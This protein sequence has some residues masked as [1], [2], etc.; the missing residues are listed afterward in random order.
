MKTFDEM[1][2]ELIDCLSK[3]DELL[4]LS[5]KNGKG[6]Y[7]NYYKSIDYIKKIKEDYKYDIVSTHFVAYRSFISPTKFDRYSKKEYRFY[8]R[9]LIRKI[10]TT[11][12]KY[13]VKINFLALAGLFEIIRLYEPSKIFDVLLFFYHNEKFDYDIYGEFLKYYDEKKYIK[14]KRKEVLKYL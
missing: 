10:L 3:N 7:Y 4:D 8:V 6:N 12:D 11:Y 1:N 14:I 9:A 2:K 13:L 5:Y